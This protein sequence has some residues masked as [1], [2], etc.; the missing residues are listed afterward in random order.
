M[1][2]PKGARREFCGKNNSTKCWEIIANAGSSSN[3]RRQR[4]I[5]QHQQQGHVPARTAESK[6]PGKTDLQK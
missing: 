6:P 2:D 3:R 5:Y 4:C 1:S